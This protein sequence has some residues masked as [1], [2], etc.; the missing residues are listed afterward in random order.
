MTAFFFGATGRQLF[1]YYH[2]AAA[3]GSRAAVICPS[4]GPE[5]QYAHRALRTL[6]RRLAERGVHVLRFD[7]S[8]TGDSWGEGRDASPD[9][10]VGDVSTAVEEL[11]AMSGTPVVD[12]VGLRFGGY[13]AA[14]AAS[15][16]ADVRRLVL[17]DPVTHGAAWLEELSGPGKAKP[18][19][20]KSDATLVEVASRV[21]SRPTLEAFRMI[22]PAAYPGDPDR[23]TMV[24][25]TGVSPDPEPLAHL[26]G[27]AFR[28]V[29]DAVPWVED[30]SIWSGLIPARSISAIAEWMTA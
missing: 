30:S 1:G 29:E 4:W 20:L 7:Y 25:R 17:W 10:W 12:L 5:Y 11:R 19:P 26:A 23:P 21:V 14:R 24:V 2:A 16:R 3:G 6:A 8:G 28:E 9:A 13:I 27:A 15:E 22:Q 18:A